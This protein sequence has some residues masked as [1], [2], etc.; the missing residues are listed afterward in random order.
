MAISAVMRWRRATAVHT[1]SEST[2]V[3]EA[4]QFGYVVLETFDL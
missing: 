2:V 4:V 1:E 3:Y